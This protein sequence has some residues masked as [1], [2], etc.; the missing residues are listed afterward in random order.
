MPE[1]HTITGILRPP[2]LIDW[3]PSNGLQVEFPATLAGG[4]NPPVCI[5]PSGTGYSIEFPPGSTAGLP[6]DFP[7]EGTIDNAPFNLPSGSQKN[8]V[9][10]FPSGGKLLVTIV[11][12]RTSRVMKA[13]IVSTGGTSAS[14]DPLPSGRSN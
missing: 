12:G 1:M 6:I 14:M 8:P 3:S 2:V 10:S 9:V 13:E 5:Q 4:S 7:I 11:P